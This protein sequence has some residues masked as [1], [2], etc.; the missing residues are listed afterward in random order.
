MSSPTHHKAASSTAI[1]LANVLATI[2]IIGTFAGRAVA[3]PATRKKLTDNG[4]EPF[5]APG[6]QVSSMIEKEM[7]QMRAIA[8]RANI[9]LD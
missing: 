1:L 7:P 6:K 4:I 3:D 9:K 5:Y 2:L 8:Q